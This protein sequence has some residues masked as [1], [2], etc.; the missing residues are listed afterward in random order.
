MVTALSLPE[1]PNWYGVLG[2]ESP[3]KATRQQ[4]HCMVY[5]PRCCPLQG[6]HLKD[7][8]WAAMGGKKVAYDIM[9]NYQDW[10]GDLTVRGDEAAIAKA[11][12]HKQPN[13]AVT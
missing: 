5:A 8:D 7:M 10:Y 9:Q 1:R 4:T 11:C 3:S 12:P 6:F 2:C 13:L